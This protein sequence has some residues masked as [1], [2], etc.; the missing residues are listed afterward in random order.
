MS[1]HFISGKPGGGKTLYAMRLILAELRN[2]NRPIVTNVAVNFAGLNAY[3]ESEGIVLRG[4][5]RDRVHILEEEQLG[6]FFCH[7]PGSQIESISKERWR[8]GDRPDYSVVK[9]SGILW[10]LDEV[11]IAFNSRAWA[12]TGQQVIYY[13]S[14]HR[15]LGD[16]VVLITQCVQNVDKQMRSVAQDFTYIRNLRKE[17]AGLFNLPGIFLR[18]TFLEPA[19]DTTRASESGTFTLDVRGVAGCY[20]TAKGVGIHGR[21]GADTLEKRHGLPWIIFPVAVVILI[22]CVVKF[23][24][25]L[26]LWATKPRVVVAAAQVNPPSVPKG[27]SYVTAAAQEFGFKPLAPAP[28]PAREERARVVVTGYGQIPGGKWVLF[29]SDGNSWTYPGQVEMLGADYVIIQGQKIPF[30]R[31]IY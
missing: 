25:G 4:H 3:C 24:P 30:G 28:G 31:G 20:D 27:G 29:T 15:K 26:V 22:I 16:D 7:R 5:I 12:D 19:G 10:V 13:L 1:I 2:S 8:N 9:D 23:T 17:R 11:H 21:A 14:Q 6:N 18:R